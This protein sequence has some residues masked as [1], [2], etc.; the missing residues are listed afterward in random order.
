[1]ASPVL[2]TGYEPFGEYETNPSGEI[3]ARLDG[4]TIDGVELTGVELPV[5]FERTTDVLIDRIEATDPIAVVAMGLAGGRH[6]LCVERV[7]INVDDCVSTPDNADHEPHDERI[8]PAGP[9]A[10]FTSLP[11]ADIIDTLLDE[12]IPA[13]LSNTA[14]THLC[15]HLL[16]TLQHHLTEADRAIPAG[17]IHVPLSSRQA[18]TRAEEAVHGGGVEP[19]LPLKTQVTG[20]ELVVEQTIQAAETAESPPAIED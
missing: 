16:Y 8:E 15:N 14:G 13:R 5:E 17:F 12:D 7:G 10:Y 4:H 19:S 11:A 20:I 1:M 2:L 6:A 9:A 18:A 3:A